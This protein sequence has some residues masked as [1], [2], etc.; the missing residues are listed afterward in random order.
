MSKKERVEILKAV[1]KLK[2][3]QKRRTPHQ[4]IYTEQL[5]QANASKV[6]LIFDALERSGVTI[7]A[8]SRL[9]KDGKKDLPFGINPGQ[10]SV[11]RESL[12]RWKAGHKV[13]DTFKLN[14]VY[15]YAVRLDLAVKKNLLPLSSVWHKEEG[16]QELKKIVKQ[17]NEEMRNSKT[18]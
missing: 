10:A 3:D 6:A 2:N 15:N 17:M 8:L 5:N 13:E 7:T 1:K 14:I 4:T 9:T 12:Y 16:M 11:S 18:S